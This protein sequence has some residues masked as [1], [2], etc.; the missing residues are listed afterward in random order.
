MSL[1]APLGD[2]LLA[3]FERLAVGAVDWPA[4]DAFDDRAF[5]QRRHWL[6][7]LAARAGG[8]PVVARL[9]EAGRTLG[10]FSGVLFHRL[11]VPILGSAF[12]GWTTPYIGFN[13]EP[14]VLRAKALRSLERFAFGEL[15]CLHLELTDRRL[16]AGEGASLGFAERV[17][18]TFL[19]DLGPSEEQ[20]FANMTSACRRAIRKAEKSGVVIEQ[21]AAEGF[22]EDYYGHLCDVFAKQGMRPTYGVERVHMLIEHVHPSGDLLL[23]RARDPEGRSIATGIYP[24][25]N[26]VSYF[27]GNGSLRQHQLLRPNEALHWFALRYWKARGIRHHD[28]A[29]ANDYKAK[30]GVR[31]YAM[32]ALRKSRFKFIRYARDTAERIYYFPRRLRRKRYDAKIAAE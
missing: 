7:F 12:R 6:E 28:W 19:T 30:Y 5:T 1:R 16:A 18:E 27:W 26:Q 24:G 25:F 10:Y 17:V 21:A 8:E 20:L 14:G 23:A 2:A 31:T 4:L 29:G 13:L 15:G 3:T 9:D 11:G 22:A 32:V